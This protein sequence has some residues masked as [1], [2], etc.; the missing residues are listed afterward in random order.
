MKTADSIEQQ[1]ERKNARDNGDK[2]RSSRENTLAVTPKRKRGDFS[3]IAAWAWKPGYC[4]N[5]GGR[6]KHDV[7]AEIARAVFTN[8]AE[9][10]YKAYLK[11]ALKGNAY[12]FKELADRAFGK[13]KERH[14][15][16]VGPYRD[17]TEAEVLERIHQ[18]EQKLGYTPQILPPVSDDPKPN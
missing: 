15:V 2:A 12:A 18:L 4:P 6:P 7:A 1:E 8:N 3:R 16:E 17:M 14:E 9:A 13:L 5:P 11:A 10:L